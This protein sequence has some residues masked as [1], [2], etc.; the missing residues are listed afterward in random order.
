MAKAGDKNTVAELNVAVNVGA[1]GVESQLNQ[2]KKQFEDFKD[3][4]EEKMKIDGAESARTGAEA[5]QKAGTSFLAGVTAAASKVQGVFLGILATPQLIE[6]AFNIGTKIGEQIRRGI[7]DAKTKVEDVKIDAMIPEVA[8]MR[9]FAPKDATAAAVALRLKV[10][11]SR[12]AERIG[13][14]LTTDSTRSQGVREG[15]R[16][17]RADDATL[18]EGL[19]GAW[20]NPIETS[21]DLEKERDQLRKELLD[22]ESGQRAAAV[23][24]RQQ[25][26]RGQYN[27]SIA[28]ADSFNTPV[29]SSIESVGNQGQLVGLMQAQLEQLRILNERSLGK[30]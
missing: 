9:G 28:E 1:E 17:Q 15:Q 4:V 27:A 6:Q 5:G 12:L 3:Y 11:E 21:D 13:S 24:A 7:I 19:R 10:V 30:R 20:M 23:R 26:Q 14:G 16:Y 18:A 22:M 29:P 2:L 25:R 8:N